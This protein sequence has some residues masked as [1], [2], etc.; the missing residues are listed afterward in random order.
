M[1]GRGGGGVWRWGF[2]QTWVHCVSHML[3]TEGFTHRRE[4][5]KNN[6]GENP[7]LHLFTRIHLTLT[8]H[9]YC[10]GAFSGFRTVS[11]MGHLNL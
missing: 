7:H 1:E 11:K 6:N 9:F 10:D 2:G 4:L 8:Y 3:S 5:L